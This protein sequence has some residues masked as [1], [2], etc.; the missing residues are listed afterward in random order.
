MGSGGLGREAGN[1][2]A[3]RPSTRPGRR[4]VSC[5]ARGHP[6]LRTQ[7]GATTGAEAQGLPPRALTAGQP[8]PGRRRLWRGS[9][10]EALPFPG[11][12]GDC[13]LGRRRTRCN[14]KT[15]ARASLG[16]RSTSTSTGTGSPTW[17]TVGRGL[18]PAGTPQGTGHLRCQ[19]RVPSKQQQ[20]WEWREPEAA[21]PGQEAWSP[22]ST[23]T[24]GKDKVKQASQTSLF[25]DNSGEVLGTQTTWSKV[26]EKSLLPVPE[27]D[28]A[29]VRLEMETRGADSP[30][31]A[32][33]PNPHRRSSPVL[34]AQMPPSGASRTQIALSC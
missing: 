26:L 6:P 12:P 34:P 23:V 30:S 25:G 14:W 11:D 32:D 31:G 3:H 9:H 27:S 18:A 29:R 19:H 4:G 17:E 1:R 24:G 13:C 5:P 10:S 33:P 15:V 7:A 2:A 8:A 21:P 16:S 28:T 22:P 20:L